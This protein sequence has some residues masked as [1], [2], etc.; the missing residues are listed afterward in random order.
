M[1]SLRVAALVAVSAFAQT[2]T[3]RPVY[4][5]LDGM[6]STGHYATAMAGYKMLAQGGNAVDAAV[7][8]AFASTVVEPSRAGIGGD[9]FS[10]IYLAK[11]R[12]VRFINATGWSP[13]RATIELLRERGNG[14]L[15][16][17][18]GLAALVP[19]AV[20]GL[21]LAAR[22]YGRLGRQRLL[23]PSIELAERGFAVSE[24]LQG[25]IRNNDARLRPFL[26]MLSLWRRNDDWV[27]MGDV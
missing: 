1:K 22:K 25:V 24:N 5:G 12:E 8:A 27:R 21:L 11:T 9:L 15:P 18:G 17:T 7:A 6:V 23:E 10:L 13:R 3:W 16:T 4:L 2:S 14:S 19:G 26:P 20:D